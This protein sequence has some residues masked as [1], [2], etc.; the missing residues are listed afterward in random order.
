[1]AVIGFNQLDLDANRA[2]RLG[3]SQIRRLRRARWR[4]AGWGMAVFVVMCTL[5]AG[6]LFLSQ[7]Q[8]APILGVVGMLLSLVAA[9]GTGLFLRQVFRLSRDLGDGDVLQLNG[10]LERILR[11]QGTG[12]YLL[13]IAGET[14]LVN[15]RLFRAVRH[16]W[17][18][19]LYA[20]PASELVLAAEPATTPASHDD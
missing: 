15:Q 12:L 9:W 13:R 19:T 3:P 2:G 1:M 14:F 11:P 6:A 10:P 16:E 18:Y 4:A 20:A 17:V 5:A 7:T 8:G